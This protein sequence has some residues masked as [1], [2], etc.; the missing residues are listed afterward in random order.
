[1]PV[2]VHRTYPESQKRICVHGAKTLFD[3]LLPRLKLEM[4]RSCYVNASCS[5][6]TASR[7]THV[8]I[9]S[10]KIELDESVSPPRHK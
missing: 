2:H 7:S 8:K 9:K 4:S 3:R 6:T 10:G 5:S 1:M